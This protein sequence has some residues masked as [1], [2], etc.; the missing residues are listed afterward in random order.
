MTCFLDGPLVIMLILGFFFLLLLF[1]AFIIF[2]TSSTDKD[3]NA[4]LS[5]K[6]SLMFGKIF[7][8]EACTYKFL[9]LKGFIF[10][11]VIV[12][13]FLVDS[14]I[15]NVVVGEGT[16]TE[17]RVEVKA[18]GVVF[19]IRFVLVE[20]SLEV[21]CEFTF[22]C[23]LQMNQHIIPLLSVFSFLSKMIKSHYDR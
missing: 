9:T 18:S 20:V 10:F 16:V 14:G 4:S 19:S 3:G 23:S 5:H 2:P 15:T 13:T 7:I 17:D 1:L 8:L 6:T 22:P 12:L 21:D 11:L